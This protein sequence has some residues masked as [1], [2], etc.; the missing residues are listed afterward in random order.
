MP[1]FESVH[2][3]A[4]DIAGQN[5]INPT[6][7]LLSAA[8]LLDY[9]GWTNEARRLEDAIARVYVGGE[10][11]P[12]DQGGSASTTAFCAAVQNVLFG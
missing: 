8:L 9:L 6:A 4:P 3:S 7:T 2:G 1:I 5:I 10:T 12:P 11:L